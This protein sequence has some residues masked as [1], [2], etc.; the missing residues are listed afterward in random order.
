MARLRSVAAHI[1]ATEP[2]ILV[3]AVVLTVVSTRLLPVVV[4]FAALFWLIRWLALGTLTVRTPLDIPLGVLVLMLPIT[5]WVTI[6]P[7]IT[8]AQIWRLLLGL[9]LYY[10][11][12][13]WLAD[14]STA[15][16]TLRLL[17][18]AAVL[19]ILGLGLALV[20][21]F[22]VDWPLA[23]LPLPTSLYTHLPKLLAEGIHPNVMAGTLVIL[24]P[25]PLAYLLFGTQAP[26]SVASTVSFLSKSL[27]TQFRLLSLI[28]LCTMLLILGLTQS[29]GAFIA[30]TVTLIFLIITRWPRSFFIL[31]VG[32]V[33]GAIFLSRQPILLQK[34]INLL[35]SGGAVSSTEVRMEAWSRAYYMLQEFPFTGIGMGTYKQVADLMYP[36]FTVPEALP[37]AHNIYLQI[38]VD[39]GLPGLIAYL[40]LLIN[41]F[42]MLTTILRA[43]HATNLQRTLAI[44]ATGSL[45]A[46]LVHGLLD[47]VTWGTKLAFIP[48]LLFALITLLF[49]GVKKAQATSLNI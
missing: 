49:L 39:L 32:V 20:A 5:A 45:T 17:G 48:W 15:V 34:V 29:R 31:L 2:Y 9:A 25:I 28:A 13:N 18:L 37:H 35:A 38:A 24:V 41:L 21:P 27:T 33:L 26:L 10:G 47:A 22:S 30:L 7:A 36:F 11:F 16:A 43:R 3:A 23:K 40:A 19:Q 42:A 4:A 1:T 12:V 44:G 14:Q 46:M 8:H 6:L